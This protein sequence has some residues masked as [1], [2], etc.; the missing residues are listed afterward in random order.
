MK[1]KTLVWWRRDRACPP[2]PPRSFTIMTYYLSG[3]Y[4]VWGEPQ[5]RGWTPRELLAGNWVFPYENRFIQISYGDGYNSLPQ[6]RWLPPPPKGRPC[7]GSVTKKL[8]KTSLPRSALERPWGGFPS[9]SGDFY[10]SGM[11][12]TDS[13]PFLQSLKISHLKPSGV[14]RSDN[15][16]IIYS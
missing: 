15:K 14:V 1:Y 6:I 5:Q 7:G 2:V 3:V 12:V 13:C 11:N 16:A 4:R 10:N 9:Y 8:K